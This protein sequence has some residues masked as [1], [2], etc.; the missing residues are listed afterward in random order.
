[1]KIPIIARKAAAVLAIVSAAFASTFAT[2]PAVA[3]SS[4]ATRYPIVLVHGLSGFDTLIIMDYFYGIRSALNGVGASQVFEP[5]ITGW[6]SNEVRGEELLAYVQDVLAATGAAKVNLIG[7][8]QGGPTSRYVAAVR[9]DLVASVTSIGSPHFGT[10][11][12]DIVAGSPLE[13]VAVT[14]GNAVG[15]LLAAL[16]GDPGQQSNAMASIAALSTAGATA[17]NA[18]Y[19]AGLRTGSCRNTPWVNVGRWWWPRWVRDYSVNDGAHQVNGVRYYSWGGTYN[20]VVD[21]N[22]L[23]LFDPVLAI[24]SVLHN[25]A[26]NDGLVAR[27][28]MHMGDNIRDDYT[29]NH[30]DE[31]NGLFALRGLF[32]SAP[33]PVYKAHAR[34]LKSAGL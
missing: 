19:P 34:R 22:V 3:D 23:D 18:Q 12:A 7:H 25:G 21:S 6:E 8:S 11:V 31:I 4:G 27:C 13:G 14:L 17:F 15:T 33:V 9:P 16:S 24:T 5:Q 20:A 29:M 10:N 28:S 32:T 1:M 26:A 2:N 30:L